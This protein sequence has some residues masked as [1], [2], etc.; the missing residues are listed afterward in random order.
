MSLELKN[1][2]LINEQ[3]DEQPTEQATAQPPEQA[4]EQ[5]GEQPTEHII[6]KLNLFFN[7]IIN[8]NSSTQ[9]LKIPLEDKE[10]I[11]MYLERLDI[12]IDNPTVLEFFSEEKI[13]E[14]KIL[15]WVIKEIYF[16]PQRILLNTLTREQLYF[17]YGKAKKYMDLTKCNIYEFLAYFITCMNEELEEGSGI[18]DRKNK[19]K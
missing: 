16:S 13:L 18:N 2:E 10:N 3:A 8:N 12:F 7:Y 14:Y 4:D 9:K 17:R 11:I 1:D 6:T 5:A 15:Y 19:R